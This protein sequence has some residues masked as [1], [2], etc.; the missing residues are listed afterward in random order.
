VVLVMLGLVYSKLMRNK[1]HFSEAA[2]LSDHSAAVF[3]PSSLSSPRDPS[4]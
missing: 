3:L 1:F 4:V 2:E